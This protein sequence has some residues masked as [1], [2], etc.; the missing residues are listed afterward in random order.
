MANILDEILSVKRREVEK[1]KRER[2]LPLIEK[3]LASLPHPR[4]M[5]ESIASGS[6][7]ISEFKRKSPSKGWIHPDARVEEVVPSY[8]RAG[9]SALSILT[10]REFFGGDSAF[11]ETARPLT[12]LPILRKEFVIDEYQVYEARAIGADAILVIAAAMTPER[13]RALCRKAHELD[14][15]VLM[16]VHCLRELDSFNEYVDMI[17]V[18]NRDLRVFRTDPE[19]SVSLFES[20][21]KEALPVS[22]SGL[23]D[24]GVAAR[25]RKV[26]YRGFLVGEAFMKEEDPGL[27][28]SNYISSIEAALKD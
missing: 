6:G 26:G 23:L 4:S 3:A 28:L 7:I 21:P 19:V 2:P 13:A 18:N 20:L 11:V 17:G 8:T 24:P 5:R 27:A 12:H 22:E 15:E 10:D 9:A 16:E 1:A 25:L 14:L